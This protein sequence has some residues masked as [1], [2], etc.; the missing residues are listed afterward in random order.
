VVYLEIALA[1]DEQNAEGEL[2]I[3]T[4]NGREGKA[5]HGD[6]TIKKEVEFLSASR[7]S[8]LLNKTKKGKCF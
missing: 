3:K 2:N 8:L 7:T 4:Q 6:E 5:E 1:K